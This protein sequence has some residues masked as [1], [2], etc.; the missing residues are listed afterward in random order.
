MKELLIPACLLVLSD[1]PASGV[2]EEVAYRAEGGTVLTR[3][4]EA[5]SKL[6]LEDMEFFVDGEEIETDAEL[7]EY[8]IESLERIV[9]T[10][11]ILEAGDGRPT[12]FLR[13]FDELLQESTYWIGENEVE[14][15]SGSALQGRTVRFYWDDEDEDYVVEANDDEEELEERTIDWLAEDMDLRRALPDGEVEE[16]DEWEVD[17]AAYLTL[18]WPG[19]LLDFVDEGAEEKDANQREMNEEIIENLEG[20][21][22]ATL[23][24]V[25]EEDG[26]RVAVLGVQFEI[27][28]WA[29]A[30]LEV[31]DLPGIELEIT[32]ER[33]VGGEI[34]WDLDH[35]HLYSAILEA[36]TKLVRK[37]SRSVETEDGEL[38]LE[39]VQTF[40]G[41]I[42]YTTEIER[43][44]VD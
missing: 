17:P 41:T 27:E 10:D 30:D 26:V 2:L 13:T 25:R 12:D 39:T 6:E 11:E 18:M 20:T 38:E 32:I 21:G 28:T 34:L 3:T 37:E 7:P 9:V 43:A 8:E 44:R 33:T 22:T 14:T 15:A 36:D 16:G 35:G 42:E 4:F 1:G 40:E 23:T 19:G 29:D 5:R 24:E 31:E